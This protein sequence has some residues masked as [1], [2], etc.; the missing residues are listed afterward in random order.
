MLEEEGKLFL[1]QPQV[2]RLGLLLAQEV[3]RSLNSIHYAHNCFVVVSWIVPIALQSSLSQR[4]HFM[5]GQDHMRAT[6]LSKEDLFVMTAGMMLTQEWCA[7]LFLYS[8]H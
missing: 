6:S 3:D 2:W 8:L 1:V 7:G 5:E 4:L